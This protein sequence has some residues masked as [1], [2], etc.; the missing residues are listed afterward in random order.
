M[1]PVNGDRLPSGDRTAESII[2]VDNVAIVLRARLLRRRHWLNLIGGVV[3]WHH[4][5]L[6]FTHGVASTGSSLNVWPHGATA[7]ALTN[8]FVVQARL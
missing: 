1:K 6:L 8:E 2:V 5:I 3:L 4:G 7:V